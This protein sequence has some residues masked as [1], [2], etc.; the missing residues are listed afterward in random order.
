MAAIILLMGIAAAVFFSIHGDPG[1]TA[2]AIMERKG[3]P[4]GGKQEEK[5]KKQ[6]NRFF[7]ICFNGTKVQI[8]YPGFLLF[9]DCGSQLLLKGI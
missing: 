8:L 6:C 9:P 2:L 7:H 4:G 3:N 1:N 5:S